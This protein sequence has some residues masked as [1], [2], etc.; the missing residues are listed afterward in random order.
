MPT[1]VIATVNQLA[2]ACKKY[3]VFLDKKKMT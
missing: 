3:K 2:T 1:E